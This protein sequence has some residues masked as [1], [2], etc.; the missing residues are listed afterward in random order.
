MITGAVVEL[1]D[2][3]CR[4]TWT[5]VWVTPELPEN[6]SSR[7]VLL[8]PGVATSDIISWGRQLPVVTKFANL[9]RF[10]VYV[11][12]KLRLNA[13]KFAHFVINCTVLL[14]IGRFRRGSVAWPFWVKAT[15]NAADLYLKYTG[16][17]KFW[18]VMVCLSAKLGWSQQWMRTT[19]WDPG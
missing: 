7:S 13:I 1:T 19:P 4:F 3:V 6:Q 16:S 8:N 11:P 15:S 5:F 12:S 9:L 17:R 18:L 10:H 14:S 2:G